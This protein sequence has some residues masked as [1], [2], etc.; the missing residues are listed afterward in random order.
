MRRFLKTSFSGAL[1][2]LLLFS[3]PNARP[4]QKHDKKEKPLKKEVISFGG[5]I[6]FATEGGLSEQTCFHLAGRVTADGGFFGDF[7]RIDGEGGVEY[8][9]ANKVVTEFPEALHVAFEI[10]DIPCKTRL[11]APGPRRYLTQEMMKSL[12]FSFYWKRG[13]ELRHIGNLRA[14]S[15][16]A[17]PVEPFNKEGTEELPKRYRWIIAFNIPSA[18]VPLTDRLVLIIRTPDGHRAARVAARL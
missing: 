1:A 7:K 11:Q 13:V 14:A 5:G 15:A 6:L 17:E 9:S 18:G 10:F 16:T 2:L 3:V 8:R 4:Q 12:A